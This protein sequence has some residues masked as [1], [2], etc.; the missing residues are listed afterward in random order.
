MSDKNQE[1][2]TIES[3]ADNHTDVDKSK[4]KFSK[5]GIAV[6]VIMTLASKP[7]FAVQA[8]SNMVSGAGSNVLP[9]GCLPG[10]NR[11]GGMSPGFWKNP[12]GKTD[13]FGDI[14][15]SANPKLIDGLPAGTIGAWEIAGFTY[16]EYDTTG[17]TQ[18]STSYD[19]GTTYFI[20]DT[21]TKNYVFGDR[22]LRVILNE[23]PGSD[24]FH[25][26]AG[27]LN[28][29]YFEAKALASGGTTQYFFTVAQFW[30]MYDN[31]GSYFVAPFPYT[32]LVDLI[33][34]NYHFGPGSNTA[35]V[36]CT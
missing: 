18:Q 10:D 25:L 23:D 4:R 22:P 28:A 19:G 9:G 20:D 31:P 24:N 3:V 15:T 16:G 2:E 36:P 12:T 7:V 8:L 32:S 11:Y 30:N 13:P 21:G 34:S 27:L 35:N 26:I 29:S 14:C 6:P 17:N 1:Q 33:S 5:A